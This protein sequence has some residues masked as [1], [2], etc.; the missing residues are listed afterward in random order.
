MGCFISYKVF[1]DF[2]TFLNWLAREKSNVY[3]ID[4]YL[5]DFIFAGNNATICS[6]IMNTFNSICYELEVPLAEDKS[7]GPKTCLTF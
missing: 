6:D 7:V 1:E 5:D 2:A 4:H 3:T